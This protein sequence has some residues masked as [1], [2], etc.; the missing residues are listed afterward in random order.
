MTAAAFQKH[1]FAQMPDPQGCLALFDHLP[2]VFF[3][4]KDAEGRFVTLNTAARGRLG[5]RHSHEAI[6]KTDADFLPNELAQNF[7]ND[8]LKVIRSGKPLIDRLEVWFDEQ[9][10]PQWFITTKL[11]IKGR[12]GRCIGVMAVI[13]RYE[14]Q[15]SHHHIREAAA[16]VAYLR[17]NVSRV[18]TF[19][20]LA[21]AV[22]ASER[23]L[24]RKLQQAFGITPYELM[25]RMRIEAAAE[26][27]TSTNAPLSDIAMDHGFCD[28]SAFTKHFRQRTGLTPRQFRMRHRPFGPAAVSAGLNG[29]HLRE[30]TARLA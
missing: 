9:G 27:L 16:A 25:L 22:G 3:L 29:S 18:R 30:P 5:V 15:R 10:L 6:G 8:D 26:A 13:R 14:E 23:N 17:A 12:N 4:A 19:A 7:R 21:K 28:Q 11:P 2:G 20:Q 24:H 1:F